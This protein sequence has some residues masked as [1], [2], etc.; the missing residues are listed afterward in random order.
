MFKMKFMFHQCLKTQDFTDINDYIENEG[1]KSCRNGKMEKQPRTSGDAAEKASMVAKYINEEVKEGYAA[2][3]L[4]DVLK[5]IIHAEPKLGL[6]SAAVVKK[7]KINSTTDVPYALVDY[8]KNR[9]PEFLQSLQ[10]DPLEE[11]AN[12]MQNKAD[13]DRVKIAKVL[14]QTKLREDK[15]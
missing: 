5:T 4:G 6:W 2:K 3:N 7:A 15:K 14:M 10:R 12:M 1:P 11:K 9:F 13:K 8:F